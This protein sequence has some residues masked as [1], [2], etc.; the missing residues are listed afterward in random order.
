[1][2]AQYLVM[3][4]GRESERSSENISRPAK[5]VWKGLGFSSLIVYVTFPITAVKTSLVLFFHLAVFNVV[6]AL[7]Q[8]LLKHL[9]IFFNAHAHWLLHSCECTLWLLLIYFQ[10]QQNGCHLLIWACLFRPRPCHSPGYEV[11][12]FRAPTSCDANI[13]S[14][15]VN[16]THVTENS[17]FM[18]YA[19]NT[20][21]CSTVNRIFRFSLDAE[22]VWRQRVK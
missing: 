16:A 13:F 11:C 6:F 8:F 22:G 15:L 1:M 18:H 20:K 2:P 3:A 4:A 21:F 5:T 19:N 10:S 12:L 7:T 9:D 14:V 17:T